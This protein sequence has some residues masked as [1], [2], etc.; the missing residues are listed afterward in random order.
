MKLSER[1]K[2]K[3]F[4]LNEDIGVIVHTLDD[5]GAWHTATA[6]VGRVYTDIPEDERDEEEFQ[7]YNPICDLL[8][9]WETTTEWN[10]LMFKNTVDAEF[11]WI[12]KINGIK[13]DGICILSP[14]KRIFIGQ[15]SIFI[16]LANSTWRA[17]ENRLH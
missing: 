14:E 5:M 4:S 12:D 8:V 17:L 3:G 9:H 15:T 2:E 11:G 10:L 6:T 1:L 13:I 16:D 7:D